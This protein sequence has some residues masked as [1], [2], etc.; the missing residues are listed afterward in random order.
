M[1]TLE[2][3]RD[4]ER[5]AREK[6]EAALQAQQEA[7]ERAVRKKQE[8]DE[9]TARLLQETLERQ[10]QA[11][12]A[13]AARQSQ[14]AAEKERQETDAQAA[15]EAQEAQ[16]NKEKAARKAY[17][18]AERKREFEARAAVTVQ[19]ARED[20]ERREI[21]ENTNPLKESTESGN[22]KA[23][24]KA[25][26][27]RDVAEKARREAE[28]TEMWN[29]DKE[30]AARK[31]QRVAEKEQREAPTSIVSQVQGSAKNLY[32][33]AAEKPTRERPEK[34]KVRTAATAARHAQEATIS[35]AQPTEKAVEDDPVYSMKSK[36]AIIQ[37]Q[38]EDLTAA[39]EA[40][41]VARKAARLA[42]DKTRLPTRKTQNIS[43]NKVYQQKEASPTDPQ[44]SAKVRMAMMKKPTDDQQATQNARRHT[45]KAAEND[46]VYSVNARLAI[47]EKQEADRIA[48]METEK[49]T[50]K[51]IRKSARPTK[52]R[53]GTLKS[54]SKPPQH[55]TNSITIPTVFETPSLHTRSPVP[56][57][58]KSSKPPQAPT[59]SSARSKKP[60][61]YTDDPMDI[62]SM[63]DSPIPVVGLVQRPPIPA[64]PSVSFPTTAPSQSFLLIPVTVE[65]AKTGN[66]TAKPG[67]GRRQP[68]GKSVSVEPA[69]KAH[70]NTV[71]E[72]CTDC[73]SSSFELSRLVLTV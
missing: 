58:K 64:R 37:K 29:M 36:L 68:K 51:V 56:A 60:V 21:A 72:L 57:P 38:E 6:Q 48:A 35:T 69:S 10:Q 66:S 54:T 63:E 73:L 30:G 20:R 43:Q 65:E 14:R 16:E 4:E 24:A 40:E 3:R 22:Q 71:S 15:R 13:K 50:K 39:L 70:K 53:G 2:M 17:D 7:A 32:R 8:T 11:A 1:R 19:K 31:A 18:D 12:A 41:K 52:D 59:R 62:D 23:G 61:I 28:V 55:T 27:D 46:P 42:R 49:V 25:T 67:I 33:K 26:R 47:I 9:G 44:H 45:P 34:M 5:K